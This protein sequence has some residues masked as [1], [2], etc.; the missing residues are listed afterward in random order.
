[1]CLGKPTNIY[2]RSLYV[3]VNV[4]APINTFYTTLILG[5]TFQLC[6]TALD[7]FCIYEILLY[8]AR[9]FKSWVLACSYLVNKT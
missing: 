9:F 8:K 5:H 2:T 7:Q 4:L 6:V 3:Y 1:M